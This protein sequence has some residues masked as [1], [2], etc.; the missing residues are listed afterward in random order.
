MVLLFGFYEIAERA[1]LPNASRDTIWVLH[2]ARGV[3]ASLITGTFAFMMVMKT[4]R[5]YERVTQWHID[6]LNAEV[7]RTRTLTE[8]LFDSLRDRVVVTDLTGRVVRAN[9]VAREAAGGHEL[10]GHVCSGVFTECRAGC[11]ARDILEAQAPSGHGVRHDARTGRVWALDA[12][13]IPDLLGKPRLVLEVGRDVT[14]EKKLE[15]HM[16][17]REKMASLGMLAAGIAHDIGNPLASLSSELELLE[18]ETD[19][20][21][22]KSSNVVLRTH[23]QRIGRTLREFVD[24]ARRRGEDQIDV[25]VATAVADSLRL[26]QHDPRMRAV[27]LISDVPCDLRSVKMVEDHLVMVLVN[28]LL[29]ALDALAAGGTLEVRAAVSGDR[30]VIAVRD[31]GDGMPPEVLARALEPLFT[32][33]GDRGGTGLG[34]A[35]SDSVVRAVGGELTIA[36]AI[37]QGTT[38][39]I[40][41][42]TGRS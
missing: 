17:H 41:L 1:W 39:T 38:V 18:G 32:T 7:E 31:T 14:E 4:R 22:F 33:K 5:Y 13:S 26:V 11:V 10:E 29:N 16:R 19:I 28:L 6:D 42:P 25:C 3:A 24:F 30:V 34:L 40:S 15:A 21:A 35:V 37:G 2:L 27:S 20:S 23:V 12:Y 9:K 8:H 36:S